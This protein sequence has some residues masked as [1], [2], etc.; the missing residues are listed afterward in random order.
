MNLAVP[1][2]SSLSLRPRGRGRAARHKF[3][4]EHRILT[5]RP[6]S[7]PSFSDRG[8]PAPPNSR[9][10]PRPTAFPVGSARLSSPA[11]PNPPVSVASLRPLRLPST[12]RP[13]QPIPGARFPS[14]SFFPPNILVG[15][16]VFPGGPDAL[17]TGPC[18]G[19]NGRRLPRRGCW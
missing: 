3:H 16:I 19:P 15:N 18:A 11:A 13:P 2:H 1:G 12:R 9:L 8:G 10:S 14:P 6:L 4:Q 7:Y 5:V 17:R